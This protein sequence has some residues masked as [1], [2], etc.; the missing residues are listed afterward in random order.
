MLNVNCAVKL[1]EHFVYGITAI[2]KTLQFGNL[3]FASCLSHSFSICICIG[4]Q[5]VR[6]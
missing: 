2:F 1:V 3:N 5:G 4:G 6:V